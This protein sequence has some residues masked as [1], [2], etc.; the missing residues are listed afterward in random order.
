MEERSNYNKIEGPMLLAPLT[1]ADG[2]EQQVNRLVPPGHG[3]V[4]RAPAPVDQAL[5]SPDLVLAEE[6][7]VYSAA[8][9]IPDS[10]HELLRANSH[11]G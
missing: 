8:G 4:P 5:N 9:H 6:I 7:D 3:D 10:L 11:A 2:P 1:L